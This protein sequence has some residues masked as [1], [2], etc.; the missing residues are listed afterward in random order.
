MNRT[1]EGIQERPAEEAS[2][3]LGN[4]LPTLKRVN[5]DDKSAVTYVTAISSCAR[6][7]VSVQMSQAT[8]KLEL[9]LDFLARELELEKSR[10]LKL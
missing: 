8:S 2:P 3:D 7:P 5:D 4:T 9:Q 1:I 10:R 6:N